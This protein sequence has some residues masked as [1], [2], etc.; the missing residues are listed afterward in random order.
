MP[1]SH[2]T[3]KKDRKKEE[4]LRVLFI[5]TGNSARSQIAEV[6]VRQMSKGRI[7]AFSAGS[8]PRSEIHPL[9]RAAVRKLFGIEMENQYPKPLGPFIGQRFNYVIS[10]CDRA[11]ASCPVFPGETERIHWSF[12]DPAAVEGDEE[13]KRRAFEE[14]SRDMASRIR[15]WLSLPA[16][17]SRWADDKTGDAG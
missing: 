3:E 15:L 5:C 1:S 8:E 12:E 9:A 10:V 14:T 17:N 7:E 4:S 2:R 6:L 13:K 16:V 11:D